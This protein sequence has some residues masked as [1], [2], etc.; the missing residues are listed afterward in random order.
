MLMINADDL[1]RTKEITDRII[2][3]YRKTRIHAASMM[4]FMADSERA[5][6]LAIQNGLPVG[7]H[8]NL[9][10]NYTGDKVKSQLRDRHDRVVS[11]LN[12]RKINQ[13]IYN[14]MLR[15]AFEYVFKS[16]WD[17]FC[18][19]YGEVPKRLDGHHHMHLCMNMIFSGLYPKGIKI[20][21][22]FTFHSGEKNAF[23]RL[24]RYL[25]DR[26][27]TSRFQCTDSFFSVAPVDQER[28]KR[29]VLLSR[30]SD[31]ELM[32]HP[33]VHEEYEFLLSPQWESLILGD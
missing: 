20:R 18:R 14:P 10:L 3:C 9:T 32:V 27:L 4:I 6:E 7:L 29:L 25:L 23:N 19:L 1:G 11:Y 16:Q 12:A 24:Y 28:L 5:T 8:L 33:G 15:S 30:S 13:L 22:N 2:N 21:R 31:M 26:W 17:E